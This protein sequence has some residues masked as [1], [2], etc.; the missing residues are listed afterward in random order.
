MDQ[1]YKIFISYSRADL[2]LVLSIKAVIEKETGLLCWMDLDN[3]ASGTQSFPKVIV[4]GISRSDI[5]LFMLSK[6]SQKSEF[7]LNELYFA[8]KRKKH[9]VIINIDGCY[10]EDEFD[11]LYGLSDIINWQDRPQR[12]KIL[13]DICQWN[14]SRIIKYS[15]NLFEKAQ[16]LYWKGNYNE[17]FSLFRIIAEQGNPKA[18]SNLG[19]MYRNGKGVN[20]DYSKAI[21]WFKRAAEQ[22]DIRSQYAL[23]IMYTY[24]RG[25]EHNL[26][27]AIK[28]YKIAAKQ[29]HLG[30]QRELEK[31]NIKN[32][33]K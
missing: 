4:E 3:I 33:A 29:G 23:G 18:Q 12:V 20:K 26:D 2:E 14:D 31:I 32:S 28:W 13:R 1:K 27:E 24:S 16:D 7:A 17:A 9:V 25:V 11:F 19:L 6:L 8:T 15:T 21:Y 10:M 22:G 30:A 5:F